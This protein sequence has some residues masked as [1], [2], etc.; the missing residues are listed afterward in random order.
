MGHRGAINRGVVRVSLEVMLWGVL[1]V[2]AVVTRFWDLGNRALNH[3]ES[4]HTLYSWYLVS[5]FRYI[6]DPMMHGPGLFHSNALIYFLFGAND[7]TSRVVPAILGVCI[8]FLPL[9]IRQPQLLGRWGALISGT[10]LLFSPT[11]LFYTRFIRHDPY[12][13][14]CT[15]VIIF[16]M[17]RYMLDRQTKWIIFVWLTTGFLFTTLEVS[18]IIAFILVTF[19]G[20][21][22]AWQLDKRLL[23]VA[24]LAGLAGAVVW[25]GMPRFGIDSLPTIPWEDPSQE[26]IQQFTVNVLFHP[27]TLALL[28]ILVVAVLATLHLLRRMRPPE[29]GWI[30]GTLGQLPEATTTGAIYDGLRDKRG[31]IYGIL[32]GLAIYSVLYTTFFTNFAGLASGT[33]GSLGYWLGQQEV[34]RGGQPWFYYLMLLP[35]YDFV[36]VTLIPICAGITIWRIAGRMRAGVE[37]GPRLYLRGLCLYWGTMMLIILSWAGEKMPWL[38]VHIALPFIILAGSYL[39]GAV[40]WLE[41]RIANGLL[42]RSVPAAGTAGILAISATGFLLWAWGTA[43]PEGVSGRQRIVVGVRPVIEEQPWLLYLP[44]LALAVV[45][46]VLVA[47]YGWKTSLAT[48]AVAIAAALVLAQGNTGIRFAMHEGDWPRDMLNFSQASPDV[49]MLMHDIQQLSFEL[50]G[51]NDIYVAWDQG[52]SWPMQWYLKDFPNRRFYGNNVASVLD[53]DVIMIANANLNTTGRD[54]V[55]INNEALLTNYTPQQYTLRWFFPER[56][57]YRAFAIAPELSDPNIQNYQTDQEGPYSL[58]DVLRSVGNS[59]A[60]LRNIEQQAK[61]FRLTAYRELPTTTL[62]PYHFRVYVRN[63]LVP[64]WDD[65]RFQ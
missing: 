24:G 51:R 25:K 44:L 42:P 1:G 5:D 61:L 50:T 28:G 55:A 39:G 10:L 52:V 2:L 58:T 45:T 32:G 34:Q 29:T 4:L 23:L 26:N 9:L 53:A 30:D 40:E 22:I 18:F 64:V 54:G 7:Y 62:G 31:M 56:E 60:S 13:L 19:V 33:V 48:T 20:I 35:Q 17:L 8:V 46:V 38:S 21:I 49:P 57:T 16:S 15:L 14:F 37:V 65:L 3:D 47:R 12:V 36:I 6:H 43:G 27:I 59:F 63:D 41:S 11:I